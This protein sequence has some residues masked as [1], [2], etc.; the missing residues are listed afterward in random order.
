MHKSDQALK[1]E[2]M[3]SLC[4]D[5]AREYSSMKLLI[6]YLAKQLRIPQTYKIITEC[7]EL[8]DLDNKIQ[9]MHDKRICLEAVIN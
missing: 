2:M 1:R 4:T 7:G 6:H 3:S 9:M 5:E 8:L